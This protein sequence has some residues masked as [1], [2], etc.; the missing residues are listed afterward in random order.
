MRVLIATDGKPH[1]ELAIEMG[2]KLTE[3]GNVELSVLTVIASERQRPQG[4]AILDAA[5]AINGLIRVGLPAAQIQEAA[6][7]G[8]FDLIVVGYCPEHS[9]LA[10]WRGTTHTYLMNTC[11]RPLLVAKGH[12]GSLNH[13]LVCEGGGPQPTLLSRLMRQLPQLLHQESS[14][15]VLHVMSQMSAGHGSA[16]QL[17]YDWQLAAPAQV[18]INSHSVEGEL[19]AQDVNALAQISVDTTPI[20]RHGLVV[21]EVVA[22]AASGKY[23]LIVLGAHHTEGWVRL[24]LADQAQQ[25]VTRVETPVLIIH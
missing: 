23:G 1:S 24:L 11:C 13:I 2:R 3:L 8:A 16:D 20:V 19:L 10:R 9:P 18:L 4:Q 12:L 7:E 6:D 21:D 5:N 17:A 14:I 22:E 15:N 25:I